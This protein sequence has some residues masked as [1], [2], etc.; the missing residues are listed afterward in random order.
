M[1][2]RSDEFQQL[3]YL[4]HHQLAPGAE[5]TESKFLRDKAT[6]TNR[7][8]DI[9]IETQ[10][11]GY[12]L[13]ICVECQKRGRV[14]DVEW[15]EQMIGKHETLPTDKLI[16]VSRSGFT[17][18]ARKKAS[19]N[20]VETL[21][22]AQAV[23]AN[24][25][26]LVGQPDVLLEKWSIEPRAYFGLSPQYGKRSSPIELNPDQQLHGSDDEDEILMVREVVDLLI[27]ENA[28][29]IVKQL[30]H[31]AIN[32]QKPYV[33]FTLEFPFPA[34]TYTVDPSGVKQEVIALH[35]FLR[36]S[37]ENEAINMQH[38]VF[39]PAQIAF[40]TTRTID[41]KALLSIVEHE[42]ENKPNTAAILLPSSTSGI[43][44]VDLKQ[45]DDFSV[46]HVDPT[47]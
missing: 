2:K 3:I 12:A 33:L 44:I 20:R 24:W 27:G 25:T 4:I 9:A 1:P 19:E 34:N 11:G 38:G 16:L 43:R 35:V 39:G 45:V 17:Q 40:G 10:V 14:V 36:G 31:S 6:G 7:E 29:N 23:S 8:V 30:G 32:E 21:T 47:N 46:G 5:V 26:T 41:P 22:I 15:I 28:E 37:R 42:Q 13:T 18:T